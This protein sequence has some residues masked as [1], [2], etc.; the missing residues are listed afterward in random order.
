MSATIGNFYQ[1]VSRAI[2][3]GTVYD[4]DISGYASD[5]VRELEDMEN[6]KYMWQQDTGTLTVDDTTLT[7]VRVKSIRSM[8]LKSDSGT[9]IPLRKVQYED[10][11]AQESGRPGAYWMQTKDILEF[12][13]VPDKAYNYRLGYFQYSPTPLVDALAW[14]TIGED[15]LIARTIRK[16]QPLLRDDKI[17]ARWANIEAVKLPALQESDLVS[18][19]DGEDNTVVPFAR[20]LEELDVDAA[21]FT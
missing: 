5:A 1:R 10:V 6:W 14:L 3:R 12:D 9:F 20:E 7:K 16:M 8:K 15:L 21:E 19:I 4:D 17:L 2:R 13:S 11:T 18:E